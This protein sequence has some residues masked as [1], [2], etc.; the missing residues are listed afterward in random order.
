MSARLWL[1]TCNGVR[2]FTSARVE[3]AAA[4]IYVQAC[5]ELAMRGLNVDQLAICIGPG[6]FGVPLYTAQLAAMYGPSNHRLF[7]PKVC[8]QDE[9][10]RHTFDILVVVVG[11][12]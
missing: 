7:D 9:E 8:D 11:R 6:G 10:L 3:H 1:H 12:G 5:I 2:T 4:F